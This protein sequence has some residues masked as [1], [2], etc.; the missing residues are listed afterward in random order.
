ML[1]HY[2]LP[3]RQIN[4]AAL[5]N[6]SVKQV[7]R[8]KFELSFIL[9]DCFSEKDIAGEVFEVPVGLWRKVAHKIADNIYERITGDKGYFDTK[10]AYIAETG[11]PKRRVKRV[12]IMDQDGARHQYLTSGKR[13]VLTPRFSPKG[14]KLL[15]MSYSKRG[16]KVFVKD[17][18]SGD[19]R[20]VG[21]FPGISFAPRFSP[22]GTKAIMSVSENG[23]TN[24]YEIDFASMYN[25]KLTNSKR[26]I[27]TSP[28]YTPDGRYVIFN[29]DR[30]GSRQLY[31]MNRDGS[32]IKKISKGSGKYASPVV[33]PRG[34]FVAFTKIVSGE[35]FF[36]GVM[37]LDGSSERL[38]ANQYLVESPTWSA[39]G[40][41]VIFTEGYYPDKKGESRSHLK[42]IDITG[43]NEKI[44]KTPHYASDPEWSLVSN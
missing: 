17:L 41:V 29:S 35:G 16:P 25:K 5:V 9:W 23:A 14:D 27:N 30:S 43:Y 2:L 6:M 36:I 8:T 33:S 28:S 10:I 31:K 24:I 1:I 3:W 20:I 13:L 34:D 15:Y 19:E 40:R 39:N 12:A 22:D 21:E 4:A 11:S 37:K 44:L 38:I 26:A 7:D 32:G 18:H 42:S